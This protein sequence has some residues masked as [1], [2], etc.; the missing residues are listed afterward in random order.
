MPVSLPPKLPND[1]FLNSDSRAL[2]EMTNAQLQGRTCFELVECLVDKAFR[3]ET[4][5]MLALS[6]MLL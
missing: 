1:T 5:S 2:G 6:P 4:Q 3:A